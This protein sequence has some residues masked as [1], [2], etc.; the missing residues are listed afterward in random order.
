MKISSVYNG[1]SIKFKD[2][3][4]WVRFCRSWDG[5]FKYNGKL[6]PFFGSE[7][8]KKFVPIEYNDRIGLRVTKSRKIWMPYLF[9]L[10]ASNVNDF[11][12]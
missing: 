11:K 5:R 4:I 1:I 9:V 2:R 6:L 3:V 10:F 7:V 8:E 12:V